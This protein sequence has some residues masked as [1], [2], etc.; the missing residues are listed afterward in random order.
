MN[1]SEQKKRTRA[2]NN[3]HNAQGSVN[4]AFRSYPSEILVPETE[5]G[6]QEKYFQV[7]DRQESHEELEI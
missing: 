2:Y 6:D 1:S 7:K 4:R 3:S 5:A